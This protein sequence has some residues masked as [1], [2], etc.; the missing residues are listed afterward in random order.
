MRTLMLP[1]LPALLALAHG[2]SLHAQDVH[3]SGSVH[4]TRA[5]DASGDAGDL[6]LVNGITFQVD[7]VRLGAALPLVLRGAGVESGPGLAD[8]LLSAAVQLYRGWGPLLSVDVAAHVKPPLVAAESGAGTGEWDAGVGILA[9]AAAG[10]RNLLFADLGWWRYGD[11]PGLEFPDEVT[12]GIGAGRALG[13]RL[14]AM[15]LLSGGIDTGGEAAS[16]AL[17]AVASYRVGAAGSLAAGASVGLD[18]DAAPSLFVA[19]R[20]PLA[21]RPRAHSAS[22]AH[23]SREIGPASPPRSS[24]ASSTVPSARMSTASPCGSASA[25]RATGAPIAV[26]APSSSR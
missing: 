2:A 1:A 8:P 3:Y 10:S 13:D 20:V 5:S 17:L 23:A 7:R 25:S 4:Y 9:A 12:F 16:S 24:L 26:N 18:D 6:T 14:A 22:S 21:S 19:W 11:P 15:L